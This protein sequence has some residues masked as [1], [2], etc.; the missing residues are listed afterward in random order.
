[1]YSKGPY[2]LNLIGIIERSPN[3]KVTDAI[4]SVLGLPDLAFW[5]F[6]EAFAKY[7]NISFPEWAKD[8]RVS[9][10][11]Y[12]IIM[13][14]SLSVTLN[15][16]DI[17]SA[18]EM[19][20][21]QQIYFMSNDQSDDREVATINYY[22]AILKPWI[23][24]LENNGVRIIYNNGVKSLKINPKTMLTYGS[25]DEQGD[26]STIYDHIIISSDLGPVQSIINTTFDNYSNETLITNALKVCKDDYL[27]RMKIAPDYKVLR[28]WFDQQMNSSAPDVLETPDYTPIN[29]IAQYHLLEKEYSIWATK[30]GGSGKFTSNNN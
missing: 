18:G 15:E 19:L 17:F 2:P 10:K 16:R 26:D 8:K 4:E 1:L 20:M 5:D 30:T 22:D 27:N 21:F 24:Y 23:S 29:L 12:D 6:D 11:F 9:K 25:I 3:L 14:P 7:D 28:V 13:Q